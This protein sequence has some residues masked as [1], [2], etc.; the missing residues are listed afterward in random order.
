MAFYRSEFFKK[1]IEGNPLV[2]IDVGAR[3]GIARKWEPLK[4]SM[5]V[6]GFEPDGNECEQLNET[7]GNDQVYLPTAL[8]NKRGKIKL[9]LTRNPACCSTFEPNYAL[10]DRFLAAEDF[11]MTGSIKVNCNTLDEMIKTTDIKGVDFIKLDTQGSEPQILQGAENVLSKYHVFGI[12]VE[13]EF[14]PLLYIKVS[15]YSLM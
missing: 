12:E 13:V 6:I 5:K 7:A 14:S 3:G 10:V 11:E 1:I 2:L 8:F 4:S 15:R 9:N